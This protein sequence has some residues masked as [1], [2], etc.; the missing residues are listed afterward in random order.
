MASEKTLLTV[1]AELGL[2][3]LDDR[4]IVVKFAPEN[5]SAKI[6]RFFSMEFYVLQLCTDKLVLLPFSQQ[7]S[8]SS[9]KSRWKFLTARS[10]ASALTKTASTTLSPSPL[11]ATPFASPRSRKNSW[12]SAPPP[13]SAGT[14]SNLS[15]A[16]TTPGTDAIS[17]PPSPI[18]QNS[19]ADRK[20]HITNKGPRAR[21]FV[22]LRNKTALQIFCPARCRGSAPA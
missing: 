20:Q 9:V 10:K 6:A 4:A 19:L 21:S 18:S 2:E 8:L 22:S 1:L 14:A 5:L 12:A 15:T 17:T 7:R 13:C 11:W 16:P 3:P